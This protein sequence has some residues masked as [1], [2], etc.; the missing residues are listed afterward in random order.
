MVEKFTDAETREGDIDPIA[1]KF[2]DAFNT[3]QRNLPKA[4]AAHAVDAVNMIAA[5]HNL[6]CGASL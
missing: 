6:S 2:L 3:Y 4:A 5:K 1:Q